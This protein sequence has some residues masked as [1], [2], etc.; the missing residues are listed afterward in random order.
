M[1]LTDSGLIS[2]MHGNCPFPVETAP[3]LT[4][5]ESALMK[6][7]TQYQLAMDIYVVVMV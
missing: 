6:G 4:L 7:S 5:Q 2:G 3:S 1:Y